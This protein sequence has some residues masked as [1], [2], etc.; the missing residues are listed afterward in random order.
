MK[1]YGESGVIASQFLTSAL[2]GSGQPHVPASLAPG[3][4][5]PASII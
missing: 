1:T 2:D 4:E 3:K 5:P